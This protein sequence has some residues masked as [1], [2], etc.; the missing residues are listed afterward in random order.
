NLGINPLGL[1]ELKIIFGMPTG[2]QPPPIGFVFTFIDDFDPASISPE[3]LAADAPQTVNGRQVYRLATPPRGPE[4]VL[5][6]INSKT[7]LIADPLLLQAMHSAA[8]GVGPLAELLKQHPIGTANVHTVV[9][10]QPLR[11]LLAQAVQNPPPDVPAEV[12]ELVKN[13][14]LIHSLVW[15]IKFDNGK[16]ITRFE[17]LADDEARA[18]KLFRAAEQAIEY[19]RTQLMVELEK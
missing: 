2:P 12:A 15:R 19:V 7:G 8:E 13:I 4:L 17:I 3:F 10:I 18:E 11:P 9:A 16:M 5:D 14:I 1:A 6:M